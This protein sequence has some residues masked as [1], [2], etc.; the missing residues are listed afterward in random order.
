MP[1]VDY[2]CQHADEI[3]RGGPSR[4]SLSVLIDGMSSDQLHLF[5]KAVD[6][7]TDYTDDD[8]GLRRDLPDYI[9]HRRSVIDQRRDSSHVPLR[10]PN[11]ISCAP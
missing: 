2:M 8:A 11:E 3:I 6:K 10:R 7:E 9:V 4:D 5:A 1:V